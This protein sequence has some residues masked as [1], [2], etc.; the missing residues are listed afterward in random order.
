[1]NNLG[2]RLRQL[3]KAKDILLRQVATVLDTDT[4]VVSKFES[5]KKRP[6]ES[7]VTKL[8]EYYSINKNELLRLWLCDIVLDSIKDKE[9]AIEA[10]ELALQ[11]LKQK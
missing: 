4:A 7:Q 3:R 6:T 5:G 10:L 2:Q 9:Q 8:A 1:M 11:E